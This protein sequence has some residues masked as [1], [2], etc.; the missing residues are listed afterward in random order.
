[1]SSKSIRIPD[2]KDLESI[3]LFA[4]DLDDFARQRS[5]VIDFGKP[6]FFS[7]FQ[8][9]FFASKLKSFRLNS[10]NMH[11]EFQGYEEH[12]YLAHMG[13]F[14]MFGMD[15]GRNVGEARGNENYLPITCLEK[16]KLYESE[17]DKYE[18]IPDLIQRHADKL[19]LVIARDRQENADMF[20][21]LSYSIREVM[22]NVFEHSRAD[23][24]YYCAQYWPKSNKVEFAVTDFGIGIRRGLSENP[25]FRFET[26]KEAI[27]YSLLP[28][29][30]GKTHLPRKSANWFNSGYGLYMT[31]RLARN[32]G[33]FV[34]ASG[35][36]AIHLS[37]KTKHNYSTS[38]P[39]TALRF[40]L[41]VDEIG[42]VAA[43]LDEFRREGADIARTIE[44]SGNR[45]PSAMSLLLR[46]DYA[47]RLP[48]KADRRTFR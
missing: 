8:I 16:S 5:L 25:N 45:P 19:A 32:G 15:H 29:V 12:D 20:D 13:F 7:P 24:L 35:G 4:Q 2:Q 10:P 40:N 18:E 34:L 41:D 36:T 37:Q 42:N 33:N 9:L 38:F 27:E 46:R 28:G 30:S 14:K 44:G 21:V 26:D 48:P 23:S 3:F 11:L 22:R 17:F 39:G 47:P 43:R 6:R 1:M 31:N